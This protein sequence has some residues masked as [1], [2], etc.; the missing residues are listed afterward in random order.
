M[1]QMSVERLCILAGVAW[2]ILLGIAGGIYGA[3]LA[4]GFAWLFLF[5]DSPWPAWSEPAIL[6]VALATGL[7]IF[8]GCTAIGWAAAR[9]C[10]YAQPATRNRSRRIAAGLTVLA[11][12]AGGLGAWGIARQQA[13]IASHR[14]DDRGRATARA[15]LRAALHRFTA[16]AVDWPG[17][18]ADGAATFRLD[19]RRSGDYRLEWGIRARSMGKK[20]LSGTRRLTLDPGPAEIALPVPARALVDGYRALLSRQDADVLVDEPFLLEARLIPVLDDAEVASL[21]VGEAGRLAQGRSGLIDESSATFPV[22]FFLY[23]GELSWQAR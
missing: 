6:A 19:G 11:L 12:L 10:G 20:V 15:D 5:G 1:I 13:D 14:K 18:G 7:A 8:A 16:V 17:S 22:R 3:G 21:P 9:R 23:G 4:A 2:G